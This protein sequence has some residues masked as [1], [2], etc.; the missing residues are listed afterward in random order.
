MSQ[1]EIDSTGWRSTHWLP[2]VMTTARLRLRPLVTG[3]VTAVYEYSSNPQMTTYTLWETH[4]THHESLMYVR[5]YSLSR[6]REQVPEPLGIT[7]LEDD[8]DW[9]IGTIGCFWASKPNGTM[10]LGYS[11]A[12]PHWGHGYAVEASQ[13]MLAYCF[14]NYPIERVQ[15]RCFRENSSSA[16][17]MQK[18]GMQFEGTLRRSLFRRERYWDLHYYSILREEWTRRESLGDTLAYD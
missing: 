14:A 7:L 2:P 9:V 1:F 16:R 3:D 6:Y 18:L 13:A 10:E 17:V 8:R 15:A 4:I 12:E 5:E 11:I